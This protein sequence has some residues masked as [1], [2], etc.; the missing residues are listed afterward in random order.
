MAERGGRAGRSG[1]LVKSVR[2][3]AI[4]TNRP[5]FAGFI[6]CGWFGAPVAGPRGE[7]QTAVHQALPIATFSTRREARVALLK[8]NHK[9]EPGRY[10]AYPTAKVVRVEITVREVR[11]AEP[12]ATKA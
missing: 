6:G 9:D 10:A 4:H 2:A 5:V 8:V 11:G 3:W 1:G 12:K 7:C